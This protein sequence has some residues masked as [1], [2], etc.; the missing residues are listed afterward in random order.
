MVRCA[1]CGKEIPKGK[2][3]MYVKADG[4]VLYF[5]S[6]KCK[7]NALKLKRLGRHWKWTQSYVEFKEQQKKQAKKRGTKKEGAKAT[8]SA[9]EKSP[10]KA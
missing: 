8:K 3:I 2:G 1:F 7:K 10:K 5:C 9:E 4:K 6:S